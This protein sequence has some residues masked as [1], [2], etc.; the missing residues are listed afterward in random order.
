MHEQALAAYRG[1]MDTLVY[2]G[3]THNTPW[4][5]VTLKPDAKFTVDTSSLAVVHT[6]TLPYNWPT[7][8]SP[9][10]T[11]G[12]PVVRY[13]VAVQ[14]ASSTPTKPRPIPKRTQQQAEKTGSMVKPGPSSSGADKKRKAVEDLG[15]P[16]KRVTRSSRQ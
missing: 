7:S 10:L 2:K 6:P 11:G 1:Q 3:I 12:P 4:N 15:M 5:K 9:G 14:L 16:E 8:T 13:S